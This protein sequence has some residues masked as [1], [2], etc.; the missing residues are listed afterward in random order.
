MAYWFYAVLFGAMAISLVIGYNALYIVSFF[1]FLVNILFGN[2]FPQSVSV[3]IYLVFV[4]T[5]GKILYD[6]FA[7]KKAA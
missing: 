6:I 3:L 5:W 4:L 7:S 2:L 1:L